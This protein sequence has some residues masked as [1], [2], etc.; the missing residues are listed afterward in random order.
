MNNFVDLRK[1]MEDISGVCARE[2][3][4][5]DWSNG[6]VYMHLEVSEFIEALRGKGGDPIDELRCAVYC[7]GS[8]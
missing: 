4:D 1:Y 2:H 3:W 8:G 5:K 7:V 6:G